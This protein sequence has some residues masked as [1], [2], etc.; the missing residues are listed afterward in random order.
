MPV[1]EGHSERVFRLSEVLYGTVSDFSRWI[2]PPTSGWLM[3][4]L[5]EHWRARADELE[6]YA[7]VAALAFREC[8]S[9]LDRESRSDAAKVVTLSEASRIGGYSTDHLQREVSRG[10]IPNAGRRNRPR[11]RVLDV[12]VKPGHTCA[13][14]SREPVNQFSARRRIVAD[15]QKRT[16][17]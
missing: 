13:L 3:S 12:P 4:N 5:A 1:R 14:P 16:G 2:L 10:K 11:L 6:L 15:A 7:P 17:A 9:D 8:A